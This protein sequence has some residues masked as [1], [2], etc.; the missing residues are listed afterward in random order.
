[1]SMAA[2]ANGFVCDDCGAHLRLY[3][4]HD[5]RPHPVIHIT[6]ERTRGGSKMDQWTSMTPP[7]NTTNEGRAVGPAFQHRP[8]GNPTE[9]SHR[10]LVDRTLV[11]IGIT[12]EGAHCTYRPMD[13]VSGRP[14][15][16]QEQLRPHI[17]ILCTIHALK[18]VRAL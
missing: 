1:M 4:S 14:S 8:N 12:L 18:A 13:S 16:I 2:T 15:A 9:S 3:E 10:K 7:R 17:G 6:P 11:C 5:C